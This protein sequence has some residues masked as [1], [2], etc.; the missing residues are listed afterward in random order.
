MLKIS[1]LLL[2]LALA[3][4]SCAGSETEEASKESVVSSEDDSA[5]D[6]DSGNADDNANSELAKAIG[7]EIGND[8]DSFSLRDEE[9]LC[10]GQKVIDSIGEDRLSELGVSAEDA[11]AIDDADFRIDEEA[12]LLNALVDCVD[13]RELMNQS[14]EASGLP[15]EKIK[16]IN[17]S[18]TD[19]DIDQYLE[20][21]V[22]GET[23]GQKFIDA[24][25]KCVTNS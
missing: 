23:P 20:G 12:S 3:A 15:D 22:D 1:S 14:F 7:V 2:A 9:E 8:D 4:S 11:S 25:E 18:L 19:E 5:N 10:M 6:G 24:R 17:D 21:V 16:C 13:A